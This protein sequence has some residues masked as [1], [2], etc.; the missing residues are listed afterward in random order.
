M[1]AL[2]HS[3]KQKQK[4]EIKNLVY[5]NSKYFINEVKL[6]NLLSNRDCVGMK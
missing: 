5:F 6:I 1:Q 3:K 2:I 4:T